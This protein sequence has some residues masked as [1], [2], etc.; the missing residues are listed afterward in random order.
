M[1]KVRTG[2]CV[3]VC[4]CVFPKHGH[5]TVA[6]IPHKGV[7]LGRCQQQQQSVGFINLEFVERR[8][9]EHGIEAS[10][11]GVWPRRLTSNKCCD[12]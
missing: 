1:K 9:L 10:A 3:C 5:V 6:S 11:S 2:V 8:V 4:V 7:S 12:R